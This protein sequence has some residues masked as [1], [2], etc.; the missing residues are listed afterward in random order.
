M[1]ELIPSLPPPTP[2]THTRAHKYLATY[3]V[4]D[5]TLWQGTGM[6]GVHRAVWRSLPG[7]REAEVPMA[8]S[9]ACC[10]YSI[11]LS[12]HYMN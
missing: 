11:S 2:C 10:D 8:L 3:G 7:Q 9:A 6:R 4:S 12:V 1:V 5:V